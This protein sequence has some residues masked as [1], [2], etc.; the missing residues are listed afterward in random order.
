M[1]WALLAIA[2]LVLVGWIVLK[3]MTEVDACESGCGL[4]FLLF[5]LFVIGV[6]AVGFAVFGFGCTAALFGTR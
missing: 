2:F 5:I 4:M 6:L 1:V 3:L